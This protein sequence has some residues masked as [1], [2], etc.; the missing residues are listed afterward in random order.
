MNVRLAT[1]VIIAV[2]VIGIGWS[3]INRERGVSTDLEGNVVADERKFFSDT[4]PQIFSS[5]SNETNDGSMQDL[6][7]GDDLNVDN[8]IPPV[9]NGEQKILITDGTKH[10]V[11]LSDILSGGPPQ[12]G[13]PSIDSPK[14]VSITT[15]NKEIDDVGLGIAVS[16]NGVNRFYPNQILVW[17][18]IVNDTIAG[19]AALITYCPLCGTGIVF[20]PLVNGIVT[21][22]GTSGKLWNSNLIMYDR[23]TQSY[24]SQVLGR[25][26]VGEQAGN[27]L[28][29]LPYQNMT[30]EDWKKEYPN[31]EV[32]STD[33]GFIK[34]YKDDPYGS[35][36]SDR[37]L[38]F[39]VDNTNNRYHPKALT[40][41]IEI[42]NQFKV[43]PQEELAKTGG[44]V[45][46]SF[47][48]KTLDITYNSNNQKITILD[49]AT[50]E[51]VIPVFGF[52][53]SWIS[54]HPKTEIFTKS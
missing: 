40:Y 43:Y 23:Q 33:T 17:H 42:D 27:K 2:V 19:Q 45:I 5:P 26:I 51:K 20:E 38:F 39:P 6:N 3:V 16:F 49:A 44:N 29:L 15:A 28:H 53:F 12:D 50:G 37:D 32:L 35:Y 11:P 8:A 13:I 10:T 1:G 18:E 30:Y 36:Y 52:W 48:G 24:W 9:T 31:G 47:A 54:V 21:E 4:S 34:N 25:S 7:N 14:F 41:G 46:D 22:F